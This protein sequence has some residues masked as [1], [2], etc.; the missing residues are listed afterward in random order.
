MH[1]PSASHRPEA[2]LTGIAGP[3]AGFRPG[4]RDAIDALVDERRRVLLVQRTGW[5]KSAVY[6]IATRLL[7]DRGAGPT[8]LISPLL[9]L[10]RNQIDMA[11]R[12]QVRAATINSANT[13]Q[14][15][16][17]DRQLRDDEIDL[18][19]VSPERLNNPR[20]RDQLEQV[21]APC[22]GLL[23]IDEAHCIS[24][25]GHDFR[26]DYRRV[27]TLIDRLPADLPVLGSTAT[28]NDR[29]IADVTEQLGNDLLVLRGRLDRDS[30]VL[31]AIVLPDPAARLAWLAEQVPGLPGSGIVYCLTISDVE[32]V[33][34]WLRDHGVDAQGYSG[35]TDPAE[36]EAVEQRLSDNDLKVVVATSA[37][38]MGYD[39]PDLQF[40]IHYQSP[41]SPI[42]Y[43]QQVGRA[44]R[45][46]DRAYGVLLCGHEDVDIQDYFIST[47][48]PPREQ[49]ERVVDHLTATA[50]PV[51]LDE[52]Q[53]EVN[54]GYGRLTAMLK[55]LAVE[56]AVVQA[57]STTKWERTDQVW[58]YDEDRVAHVTAMRRREQQAMRDYATTDRCLMAFLRTQLDDPD[59]TTCGRCANCAGPALAV[60]VD[61]ALANQASRHLRREVLELSPR[62]QWPRGLDSHRGRIG[63]DR[64]VEPG[65]VLCRWGRAGWGP[66]VEQAWLRD[67]RFDDRLVAA[68]VD[69]IREQWAPQPAPTWVTWVPSRRR[70][71]LVADLA[72]RLAA[73]LGL[74][75][76]DVVTIGAETLSQRSQHN[77]VQQAANA[78]DTYE[79]VTGD[80][81]SGPALLVDGLVHSQWTLT[82]VG[83]LLRDAGVAAVHPFA[84][85]TSAAS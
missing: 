33:T 9:A 37:L 62:K 79:V 29:V 41:G 25:W 68:A 63:D 23:V 82:V 77:S 11:L 31:Q 49:A 59:V 81:P 52:L 32:R 65:R 42:A 67:G 39:K 58:V 38:G 46:V 51:T 19:L 13:D 78:L 48:F 2:L 73:S 20:F 47:A 45:G 35:S 6:F 57:G 36:R 14:W 84:L 34:S 8:L 40:V 85:A 22:T 64:R 16:A 27:R 4:Q 75:A 1:T 56:G 30:L 21:V 10:M 76:Y 26:P 72:E 5:G 3:G 69:L 50:G 44:G 80:V 12:A 15:N 55:V 60:T 74:P 24:D 83:M 66:L 54:I 61:P 18:L 7:R 70:P 71:A 53:A 28:A 17:I 43:Y